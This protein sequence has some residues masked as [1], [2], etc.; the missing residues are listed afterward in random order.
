MF[1]MSNSFLENLKKR[2]S[3]YALGKNVK[4][5][6][7]EITEIIEEAIRQSPSA[8]NSQS[9]R[10]VI[11]YG[12]AHDELWDGILDILRGEVP[13]EEAFKATK[14]KVEGAFKAGLG[15]VLFYTDEDVI[16]D[17]KKNFPLY[18]DAFDMFGE[19]GMGIANVDVWTALA[20][21]GIGASL[22]HYNPIADK[23][24]AEK[25]NIPANW[26]LKAQMPFGSIEQPA[27]DKEF[28]PDDERFRVIK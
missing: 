13:N 12:K 10:A 16:A 4:L 23:F 25:F 19:H 26:T 5:S 21:E 6:E 18:K 28:M 15:T 17:L 8:F 11:L 22:Q 1:N 20:N 24:I 3:I 14:A 7:D 2:R 27:G 9:I